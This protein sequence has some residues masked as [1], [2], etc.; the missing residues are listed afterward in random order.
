VLE[1][2][3]QEKQDNFQNVKNMKNNK[4]ITYTGKDIEVLEGLEGIRKRPGMYIGDVN[5]DGM[6]QLL[7]EVIDN[8]IDEH[9][10]GYCTNII[11]RIKNDQCI[12]IDNG[13]G[14]PYDIN[15]KFN[16][17]TLE[18]LL[19]M[20]HSG[21]KFSNENYKFS[22]GLHG[23]G[24]SAVNALSS[25]L[26]VVVKRNEQ[27]VEQNFSCG[28]KITNLEKSNCIE[29]DNYKFKS[30]TFLS[31]EVDKNIMI[32]KLSK[33]RVL[34]KIFQ[35]SCLNPKL[36]MIVEYEEE[37]IIY[38]N[39]NLQKF[40]NFPCILTDNIEFFGES[41]NSQLEFIFNYSK[42]PE[43]N[44]FFVNNIHTFNGGTHVTMIKNA[45]IR[46]FSDLIKKHFPKEDIETQ[47]IK[48]GLHVVI[49]FK[50]LDPIFSGQTKERFTLS[51]SEYQY[52]N[53]IQEH[54]L[55]YFLSNVFLAK[56]LLEIFK[57]NKQERKAISE[58]RENVKKD[59]I[60]AA[61]LGGK[62]Q[63][64]STKNFLDRE[65][66]IV[67]G[68]SAGGTAKQARD[69]HTQA[70]LS[71]RG[72]FLNAGKN[73]LKK[74]IK[75]QEITTM[76]DVLGITLNNV[77]ITN[78]RYNKIVIM[79]DADHDGMH[80]VNLHLVLFFMYM[81]EI[82]E[83]GHLYLALPPLFCIRNKNKFLEYCYS[84]EELEMAEK[85]YSGQKIFIQRFKGLG[86]MNPE[87]LKITTMNINTRKLLKLKIDDILIAENQM[88][89]IMGADA[90]FRRE[91][92]MYNENSEELDLIIN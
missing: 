38:E 69:R 65:L 8:A 11:I 6:H 4:E 88:N 85:K 92:V 56:I 32:G 17:S 26:K 89:L 5:D 9:S 33:E 58:I 79:T 74:I 83:A 31:F 91:L 23:V 70:V 52:N 61:S 13:R 20:I 51:L 27:V 40:L 19:T 44:L 90:T 47:D 64:C 43:T 57:Q 15:E 80:I 84:N 42:H 73:N 12:V 22:S 2:Q 7:W 21:G 76:C 87:Q 25:N 41:K 1:V 71:M 81:R 67:E 68:E 48:T 29:F 46:F 39:N 55:K 45:I 82:I 62:L 14:I 50:V 54:L 63:D 78:L 34:T 49:N 24:L 72:K 36:K 53:L 16:I 18:V 75:N 66:F 30:G 86:E 60:D 28:K 37:I 10:S 59:I 77:Q 35:L 3:K